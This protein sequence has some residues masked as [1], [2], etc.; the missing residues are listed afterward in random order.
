MPITLQTL[1]W[2]FTNRHLLVY[3][4]TK[5]G[6]KVSFSLT[7]YKLPIYISL[8]NITLEERF[9]IEYEIRTTY[10]LSSSQVS[11]SPFRNSIAVD[12]L[13]ASTTTFLQESF[14]K[15]D[16]CSKQQ[17]EKVRYFLSNIKGKYLRSNAGETR[18]FIKQSLQ[19]FNTNMMPIQKFFMEYP[20]FHPCGWFSIQGIEMD[21]VKKQKFVQH[22]HWLNINFDVS[23]FP[24]KRL[25]L[26]PLE[27]N[28]DQCPLRI[29]SFDFETTGTKSSKDVIYQA[30]ITFATIYGEEENV[31]RFLLNV[32]PCSAIEDTVV[33]SFPDEKEFLVGFINL[34][35]SV[36]WDCLI[37]YNIFGFDLE[38]LQGRL[39]FHGISS[40]INKLHRFQ[41][42]R[43]ELC[44]VYKTKK[45]G[46]GEGYMW[47]T[48]VNLL[49]RVVLDLFPMM[50][51]YDSKLR[52]YS[53]NAVS[54]KYL[55]EKK[56]DLT[57][58]EMK[59]LYRSGTAEDFWKIGVYCVQDTKLPFG[60]LKKLDLLIYHVS[61][62][63]VAHFPF[64]LTFIY[65]ETSK[66]YSQIYSNSA[67]LGFVFLGEKKG[68]ADGGV[69]NAAEEGYEG[70]TVLEP[71][72]GVYENAVACLD[73]SSLYPSIM[74]RYNLCPSTFIDVSRLNDDQKVKLERAVQEK[75]VLKINTDDGFVYFLQRHCCVG[76]IPGIL[77]RLLAERNVA[78]KQMRTF[79]KG[80]FAFNKMNN[81]QL[82]LVRS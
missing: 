53:L 39:K 62:C 4:K 7:D 71:I 70:A 28:D 14:L 25:H 76:V 38:M 52:S 36:E 60:L 57:Y 58:K 61:F 50:K 74:I 55:G 23:L 21:S 34:L 6:L 15:I 77:I 59:Q 65:G 54:A 33:Q 78:K 24:S 10:H 37:G 49:G 22:N 20:E 9:A 63:N 80:T 16:T 82:A 75:K 5:Q 29:C 32:G 3:G 43:G 51:K 66:I 11:K 56:M 79:E 67:P 27:N 41:T 18:V 19:L 2:D 17:F 1:T 68:E 8:E 40:M 73:F 81:K 31:Q 26:V 13:T 45:S 47:L 30:G 42:M 64:N 46:K 48:Y 69:V 35:S 72:E 12:S 44:K